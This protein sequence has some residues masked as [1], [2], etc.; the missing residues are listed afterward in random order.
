MTLYCPAH[1]EF[2][3]W[4]DTRP[5]P[6]PN[7][8][9]E[10]YQE[11]I[12]NLKN[13]GVITLDVGSTYEDCYTTTPKGKAWVQMLCDVPE[14]RVAFVDEQDRVIKTQMTQFWRGI[15]DKRAA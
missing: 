9:L 3:L 1:I 15:Y 11:L 6:Y 5:K 2:L 4:C 14:P 13:S 12:I 8:S 10:M 7:Q